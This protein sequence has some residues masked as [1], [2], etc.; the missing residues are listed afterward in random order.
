MSFW[1]RIPEHWVHCDAA[2]QA[3][4]SLSWAILKI[5]KQCQI[6]LKDA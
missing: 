6:M 1:L 3:T 2:G 5:A 4:A